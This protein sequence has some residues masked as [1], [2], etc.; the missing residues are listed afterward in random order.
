MPLF[1]VN[2]VH[3]LGPYFRAALEGLYVATLADFTAKFDAI[4]SKIATLGTELQALKDQIAT[5][6]MTASE[7]EQALSR[8]AAIE[9]ALSALASPP[10][11]ETLPEE[12]V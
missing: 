12:G 5:G 7:E 6:G 9:T 1:T 11:P 8:A 3:E 2:V 10:A 4:D